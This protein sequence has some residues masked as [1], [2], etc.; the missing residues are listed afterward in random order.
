MLVAIPAVLLVGLSKGGMGEA[1]SLMGVPLLSLAV[2]PV[3]AAAL[4]LPILIA[5]DLVSLWMWRKHGDREDPVHAPARRHR[6]H[7]HR[8]GDVGLCLARL[9]APDHRPHHRA[10]RPALCLQCLAHAQRN[11]DHA[12]AATSRP[13]QRSGARLPAMAA[14][15]PTPAARLFRS[16]PCRF[17]SIRANTPARS[18]ASSPSSMPSSSSPISRSASST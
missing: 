4:L 16:T 17:S 18:C 6:R 11:N 10:V 9:S 12:Q 1:L 14:L 8:L 15:S 2:S 7:P 13:R 5:M 3:Q